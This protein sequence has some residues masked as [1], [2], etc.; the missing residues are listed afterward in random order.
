[1]KVVA[2]AKSARLEEPRHPL[3]AVKR[4]VEHRQELRQLLQARLD[5][6]LVGLA[7]AELHLHEALAVDPLHRRP[8]M[9]RLPVG[10][11]VDDRAKLGVG[12]I[13]P[14]LGLEAREIGI[15]RP[16]L[17]EHEVAV[18]QHRHL[19]VGIVR[20]QRAHFLLGGAK[21][22][23]DELERDPEFV[24]DGADAQR[25]RRQTCVVELHSLPR[26]CGRGAASCSPADGRGAQPEKPLAPRTP[27]ARG[28]HRAPWLKVPALRLEEARFGRRR[29]LC[30]ALAAPAPH[31][32]A[33]A[34]GGMLNWDQETQMPPKG[35]AQRAEHAA[36]VA[37]ALHAASLRPARSPDWIATAGP[38][39]ARRRDQSRGGGAALPPRGEGSGAVSPP[40]SPRA[41]VEGQSAWVGGA[42]RARVRRLR[43]RRSS[44]WW[45]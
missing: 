13:E 35:A 32:G 17:P 33:R 16:A 4:A 36:A 20:Q 2:I 23:V 10:P 1:M 9:D 3:L 12:R 41:A 30:R 6:L 45:R 5:R 42:R 18:H 29:R 43:C 14:R 31:R 26:S 15:D 19:G 24:G 37:S 28:R 39:D 22:H 21:V 8:E 27:D 7:R 44:A 11:L 25:V 40:I 34:G 38:Q